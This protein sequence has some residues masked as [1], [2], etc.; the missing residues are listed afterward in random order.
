MICYNSSFTSNKDKH[1]HT[2]AG[3]EQL[4]YQISQND[5]EENDYEYMFCFN[6]SF[7]YREMFDG[8]RC[9]FSFIFDIECLF[10]LKANVFSS[11]S[12]S[13]FT[14]ESGLNYQ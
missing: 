3:G 14:A 11:K 5:E 9:L 6:A 4:F 1:T 10:P 8:M 13:N 12:S 2:S 7:C